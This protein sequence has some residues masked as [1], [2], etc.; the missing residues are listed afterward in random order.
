LTYLPGSTVLFGARGEVLARLPDGIMEGGI[1]LVNVG[2]PASCS[3]CETEYTRYVNFK[4]RVTNDGQPEKG[5]VGE[6]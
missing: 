6:A 3:Y 2:A 4:V 1:A 5:R